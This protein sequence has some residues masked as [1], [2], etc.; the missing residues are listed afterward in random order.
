MNSTHLI[1]ENNEI[2]VAV[3]LF[4]TFLIIGL[5]LFLFKMKNFIISVFTYILCFFINDIKNK[6]QDLKTIK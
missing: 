3:S 1:T 2:S 4:L 6:S 5:I